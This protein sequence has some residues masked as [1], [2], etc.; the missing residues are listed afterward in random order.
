MRATA[1][2]RSEFADRTVI[3][4]AHA[5]SGTSWML[6]LL[7]AHPALCG[8]DTESN[9]FLALDD[10]WR[11]RHRPDGEGL[12]SYLSVDDLTVAMREFCDSMFAASRDL[13]KPSATWYVEKTPDNSLFL[14][15]IAVTHPD[16]WFI[17]LMRDG[18]D[19]ARSLVAAPMGPDD[20]GDAA[21]EWARNVR[22]VER[23]EWQLP[24]FRRVYYEE[25]VRDPVGHMTALFEWM[26]LDV[27]PE[28][29][30]ELGA[31]AGEEVM[32]FG[33]T[34]RVGAGKWRELPENAVEQILG[35]AG[36]VLAEYG[37]L[38]EN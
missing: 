18:R 27:G 14:P 1:P 25:L 20:Y 13:I 35:A 32:R 4:L 9:I 38:K 12:L 31:R 21:G 29:N 34:G 15:L 24:R 22:W 2:V 33:G 30:D 17:H 3:V 10:L 26:G 6:N 16:A 37:Y 8:I 23:N 5:R 28:V 36:D 19:V 7:T 11:N